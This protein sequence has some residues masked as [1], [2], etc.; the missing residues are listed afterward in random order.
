M[1]LNA[2]R[3]EPI[4]NLLKQAW[5]REPNM[6]LAQLLQQLDPALIS[7]PRSFS[8]DDFETTLNEFIASKTRKKKAS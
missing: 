6:T 7:S 3:I 5:A 4:T 1:R 8:D 2:A